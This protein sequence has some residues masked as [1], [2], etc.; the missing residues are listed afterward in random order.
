LIQIVRD[1]EG[2]KRG[3]TIETW[4]GTGG[5]G[6]AGRLLNQ[7]VERDGINSLKER[8]ERGRAHKKKSEKRERGAQDRETRGEMLVGVKDERGT[9]ATFEKHTLRNVV[10]NGEE[11]EGEKGGK[12]SRGHRDEGKAG[13]R[14]AMDF[15]ESAD[16]KKVEKSGDRAY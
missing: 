7:N 14:T 11:R 3:G 5:G 16:I 9:Q 13:R 8:P 1:N 2:E 15:G 4:V 6:I 10:E 12:K